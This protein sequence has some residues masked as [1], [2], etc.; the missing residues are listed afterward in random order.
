M[1]G[2][3]CRDALCLWFVEGLYW[4]VMF[5]LCKMYKLGLMVSSNQPVERRIL[6]EDFYSGVAFTLYCALKDQCRSHNL[7]LIAR[8]RT[9]KTLLPW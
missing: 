8:T 9:Q 1:G 4:P 7:Q 5:W 6:G 3:I 2:R